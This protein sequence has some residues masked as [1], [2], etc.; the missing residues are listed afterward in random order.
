MPVS[1]LFQAIG[2]ENRARLLN[3]LAQRGEICVC[4]LVRVLGAPQGRLSRHLAALRHAGLVTARR[5]G[6]R[7]FYAL[8]RPRSPLHRDLVRCIRAHFPEDETLSADL[9][10]F[11]QLSRR[12]Q[13]V[14]CCA[15]EAMT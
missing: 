9:R 10:T 2:E 11:D 4:D 5:D 15:Q 3:L 13:L 1:D 8:A 6:P 12:G 14:S 7:I